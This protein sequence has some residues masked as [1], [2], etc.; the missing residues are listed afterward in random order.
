MRAL[1]SQDFADFSQEIGLAAIGATDEQIE[2]LGRCY[3]FSVEF[4]LCKQ[5]DAL[6]AYGA[7]LLSSF[8][9]LKYSLGMDPE[10]KPELRKFDPFATAKQTYPITTYQP[11]YYVAESFQ[12]M[13]TQMKHFS[14]SLS[15]PFNVRYNPYTATLDIDANVKC[16]D[17]VATGKLDVYGQDKGYAN[18]V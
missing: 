8:G 6:K 18:T 14:R 4:G 11:I 9:E 13:K 7:G 12:D 17:H 1:Y 2:E 16:E 10:A 15:R 5:G 3:W